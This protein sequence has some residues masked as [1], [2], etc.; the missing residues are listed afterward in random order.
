MAVHNARIF[1]GKKYSRMA[2]YTRK[3]T[4]VMKNLRKTGKYLA[5]LTR[6]VYPS[7]KYWVIYTRAK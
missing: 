4:D 5:R 6:E 2:Y 7:G 3:P 1:N